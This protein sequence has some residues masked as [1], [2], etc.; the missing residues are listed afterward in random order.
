MPP[1]LVPDLSSADSRLCTSLAFV[2]G[3]D[4][5][6]ETFIAVSPT[7]AAAVI[8]QRDRWSRW[9]PDV[10][11]TIFMDRG[12]QG[13]RWSVIG[14][15]VGSMEIWLEAFGDGVILHYY[16]RVDPTQPGTKTELAPFAQTMT[17]EREAAKVRV[18]RAKRWK[19]LVWALKDE[20]EAGREPGSTALS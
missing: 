14:A 20:L 18:A 2:A 15:F 16:L 1:L 13:I 12:S 5:V 10:E 7:V 11:L 19:Q 6:D 9:F 4:L 17:G 8:A 3:V